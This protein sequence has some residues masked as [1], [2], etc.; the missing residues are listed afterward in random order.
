[1]VKVKIKKCTCQYYIDH[2]LPIYNGIACRKFA[3]SS[4]ALT[5]FTMY[6]F[7]FYITVWFKNQ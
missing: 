7:V 2:K 3:D 4:P 5:L 1:M 6:L